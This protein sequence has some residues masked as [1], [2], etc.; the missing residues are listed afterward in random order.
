MFSCIYPDRIEESVYNIDF[1]K[2]YDNGKRGILFDIDNT[3]VMHG[4]DADKAAEDL[5]ARLHLIG[6]KTCLISN[7]DEE[8]VVRFNKNIG[9]NYVYKAG[10]PASKGYIR[11]MELMGTDK[12][13][14]IFIGD[15]LFTDVWGAK[16]AGIPNILVKPIHPKEEI[17]IVLKRRLEAFVL[18]EYRRYARRQGTSKPDTPGY[19]RERYQKDVRSF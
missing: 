12:E 4:A 1:E 15:Q 14:T 18:M 8:R 3:L 6:F 2:L 11:G 7:N 19:L 13:N 17:Q 9:T 16:R 10:K 5:F